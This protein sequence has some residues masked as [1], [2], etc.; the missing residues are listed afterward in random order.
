M[1]LNRKQI[2]PILIQHNIDPEKGLLALLG[3]YH[4]VDI[5]TICDE[6]TIK[7]INLTK[8]VEKDYRIRGVITWNTPLFIG[9]ESGAWD[10]VRDWIEGFGRINPDRKGAFKDAVTRMKTFFA[11]NPE[12]RK[13]DVYRARD[14]YFRSLSSPMYCMNSHKF[15]YD[16]AG[17][18]K[19]STL[20]AWCEKTK[21]KEDGNNGMK[22]KLL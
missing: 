18:M 12:Y 1:E 6:A 14:A 17:D 2:V 3:I 8:I 9:I 10:W 22:G 4:G 7:A 20:L 5:E 11:Q 15:I 21:P 19:K 13:D 16:G